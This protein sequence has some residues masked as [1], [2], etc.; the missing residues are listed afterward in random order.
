[1]NRRYLGIVALLVVSL[2][3]NPA[4]AQQ[5]A[6]K[7]YFALLIANQGYS[8]EVGKLKNP[9][10]D[11]DVVE[12]ALVRIGFR[13]LTHRDLSSE[14]LLQEIEAHVQRVTAAGPGAISFFYYA[15]HG[16]AAPANTPGAAGNYIIPYNIDSLAR[17]DLWSRSVALDKILELLARA[18]NAK[19]IVI[20]D[21]CRTELNLP[22]R[23]LDKGYAPALFTQEAEM[24]T[25]FATAPKRVA[26]DRVRLDDNNGPYAIAL[27]QQL[28]KPGLDHLRLFSNV[29]VAV[30]KQTRA[31]QTPWTNDGLL[32]PLVLHDLP[33][34]A[35]GTD[36]CN[37]QRVD[38]AMRETPME[39][40]WREVPEKSWVLFKSHGYTYEQARKS[41]RMIEEVS[42]GTAYRV[43]RGTRIW[44]GS[45][46]GQVHWYRY[47]REVDRERVRHVLAADVELR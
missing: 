6:S 19:H 22:G 43:A 42:Q 36:D 41:A 4:D 30:H 40:V 9:K 18:R 28:I 39:I 32:Q 11:I 45:V 27:S 31:E 20:F 8:S 1:M 46:E 33:P 7:P 38:L 25:A 2:L 17:A 23:D 44:S 10:H 16:A 24:L 21:A 47:E 29:R 35:S 26:K 14:Q 5:T 12:S 34:T 3:H 37:I 15:G 13:V